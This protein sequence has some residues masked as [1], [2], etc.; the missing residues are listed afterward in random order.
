MWLFNF[1]LPCVYPCFFHSC[2]LRQSIVSHEILAVPTSPGLLP[3]LALLP[4]LAPSKACA[5]PDATAQRLKRVQVPPVKGTA[6]EVSP[7][8]QRVWHL[9]SGVLFWGI[10]QCV[11]GGCSI[12]GGQG[13][14]GFLPLGFPR[15]GCRRQLAG[16]ASQRSGCPSSIDTE[17]YA[18]IDQCGKRKIKA[19]QPTQFQ[20]HC[21]SS[22]T[23]S[24]HT[25]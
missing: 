23:G 16:L 10:F 14:F 11:A 18:Y 4:T 21:K 2:S 17:A 8:R 3:L 6:P 25:K 22:H 15:G 13:Q 9:G 24:Y 20:D 1:I 7:A 19:V 12:L 5:K